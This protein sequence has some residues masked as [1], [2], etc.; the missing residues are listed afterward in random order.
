MT[1]TIFTRSSTDHSRVYII[2]EAD[3]YMDVRRIT[4]RVGGCAMFTD[5]F[6]RHFTPA[7]ANGLNGVLS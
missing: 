2:A 1:Y 6:R 5:Q 3:N 4:R 7:T